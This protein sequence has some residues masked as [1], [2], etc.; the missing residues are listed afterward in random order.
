MPIKTF[1]VKNATAV[2]SLQGS[3]QDGGTAPTAATTVTG[4][5]VGKT[6]AGNF[7]RMDYSAAQAAG[8]FSTTDMFANLTSNVALSNSTI[9]TCWRTENTLDGSFVAANATNAWTFTFVFRATTTSTHSG[10]LNVKVFTSPNANGS[11][12][13]TVVDETS[14]G[15]LTFS[16]TGAMGSTTTDYTSSF[17]WTTAPAMNLFNEYLFIE[18]QWNTTVAGGTNSA[19][20]KY[21]VGSTANVV[22]TDFTPRRKLAAT[23]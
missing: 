6:A 23:T 2:N 4:W 8:T 21:R 15:K 13:V 9:G 10:R 3:L 12:N 7:S 18:C 17:T 19:D 22:S 14:G 16:N 11:A 5:T 20:V 1:Y